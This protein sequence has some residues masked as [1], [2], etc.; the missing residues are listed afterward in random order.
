MKVDLNFKIKHLDG[1]DFKELEPIGVN[2]DGQPIYK[3]SKVLTLRG[4]CTAALT[5][6]FDDDRTLD[7]KLK[8]ERGWLA[9]KIHKHGD[10]AI[11]LSA[12]DVTML[13]ALIGKR[14]GSLVVYQTWDILDPDWQK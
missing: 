2:K 6:V 13:K 8:A 10:P 4:A 14:Y 3:M 9:M 12:E 1:K 5:A 7:P 11:D